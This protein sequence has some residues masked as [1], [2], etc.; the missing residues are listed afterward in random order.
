MRQT[1]GR[2]R[3]KTE[4]RGNGEVKRLG[5]WGGGEDCMRKGY[6]AFNAH[7]SSSHWF[8]GRTGLPASAVFKAEP[9]PQSHGLL[10]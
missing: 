5:N 7:P 6:L 4:G 1:Y 9:T 10:C 3:R 2:M 8:P